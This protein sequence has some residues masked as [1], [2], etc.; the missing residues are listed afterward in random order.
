MKTTI[1]SLFALLAVVTT[2]AAQRQADV[3][4]EL[5][6]V[7]ADMLGALT[8]DTERFER[9]MKTLEGLLAKD[10]TSPVLKVLWGTGLFART[11]EAF[12]KGDMGTAMKLWQSGLAEMAQAVELAPE[13]LLV[14]GRRGVILISASRATPPEMA[15]PLLALAVSDFE[16]ILEI[17]EREHTFSQNSVH[18]RGELL[19]GLADGWNRLGNPDKA[20]G[21]FERITQDLKGTTYEE[22]A[23]GWLDGKPEAQAPAFFACTGC[24][25]DK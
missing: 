11:G 1:T 18:K 24:H 17:R 6:S 20:R 14:R 8:G 10:P 15:K 25:I 7:R 13:N 5:Q 19:T 16:K 4:T 9:G 22:R 21:Y 3:P 12:N 2:V 23:K